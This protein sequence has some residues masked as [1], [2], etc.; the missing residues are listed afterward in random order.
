MCLVF[1][2]FLGV[3]KNFLDCPLVFI[4]RYDLYPSSLLECC[5]YPQVSLETS[6]QEG[7]KPWCVLERLQVSD[8]FTWL[9]D[10]RCLLGD[11]GY[12]SFTQ[13]RWM[14]FVLRGFVQ[15]LE[16]FEWIWCSQVLQDLGESWS[17]YWEATFEPWNGSDF[18]RLRKIFI[19][20]DGIQVL[21]HLG[22]IS[23]IWT[24]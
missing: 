10:S 19:L 17:L 2:L 15:A 4:W 11:F 20:R 13:L 9:L 21:E 1:H 24:L 14:I 7:P 6:P 18:T 3:T 8:L 5:L 12:P 16:C 23:Y 22:R